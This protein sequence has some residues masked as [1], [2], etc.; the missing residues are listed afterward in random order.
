MDLKVLGRVEYLP[1]YQAM[2]AF[3]ETRGAD[4]PDQL[5]ICEHPPVFTQGLAGKADHVLDAGGA[6]RTVH[7][8]DAHRLVPVASG[9]VS[10]CLVSPTLDLG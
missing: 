4:T 10:T 5:W 6:V 2:A 3:T 8:G 9:N 1:T 7:V